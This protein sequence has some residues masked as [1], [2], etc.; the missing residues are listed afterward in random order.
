M[1][2]DKTFSLQII[3][4]VTVFVM[5]AGFAVAQKATTGTG[6][7]PNQANRSELT[8]K[9]VDKRTGRAIRNTDI[10]IYSDNG[11]RCITSPCYTNAITWTGRTGAMGTVNMP[12][13]VIQHS[14]HIRVNGYQTSVLSLNRK[15]RSGVWLVTLAAE[16]R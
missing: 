13:R 1:S 15:T 11:K 12:S 16:P 2:Q 4:L 6:D 8:L 7:P 14:M 9:L 5:A 3:F 10:E